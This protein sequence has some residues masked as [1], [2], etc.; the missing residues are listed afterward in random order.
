MKSTF[1][2]A[3][4]SLLFAGAS[5]AAEAASPGESPALSNQRLKETIERYFH[6]MQDYQQGDLICQSQVEEL[7]RYLLRAFGR[8]PTTH[9]RLLHRVLPDEAPLIRLFY[10]D[11]GADV[12][13]AAAERLHGYD[14]LQALA[15]TATGR[16]QIG[17]AISSKNPDLLADTAPLEPSPGVDSRSPD[18]AERQAHPGINHI[19]TL[20]QFIEA[21]LAPDDASKPSPKAKKP[22]KLPTAA[23]DRP[24]PAAREK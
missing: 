23:D 20:E 12:L 11:N 5:G 17:A 10:M 9:P 13:R 6:S 4:I 7:Q 2:V 18:Q 15:H 1:L 3:F 8:I 14:A 19:F 22:T 24:S 21:A 16:T